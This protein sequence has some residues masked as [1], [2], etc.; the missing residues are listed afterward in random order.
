MTEAEWRASTDPLAMLGYL[1]SACRVSRTTRGR[2]KLRLFAC[3]CIRM[4]HDDPAF[5][6]DL[7]PRVW[8][9]LG[10]GERYAEKEVTAEEVED[11]CRFVARDESRW[12]TPILRAACSAII[13]REW[14][15]ADAVAR[16]LSEEASGLGNPHDRAA[17]KEWMDDRLASLVSEIFGDPFHPVACDCSWLRWND[18]VIPK[19]AK[20]VYAERDFKRLPVL[21]DALEDAGCADAVI[22]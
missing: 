22:L 19:L 13:P 14:Q 3:A 16:R 4:L 9:V 17:L 20:A 10:V 11:T 12:S 6:V 7:D 15:A 8:N 2:R 21:A 18:G 1:R 5:L